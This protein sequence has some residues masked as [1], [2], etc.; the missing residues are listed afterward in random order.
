[1]VRLKFWSNNQRRWRLIPY[2][3]PLFIE[4]MPAS[5]SE[6]FI[7]VYLC[8]RIKVVMMLLIYVLRGAFV[9]LLDVKSGVRE[10]VIVFDIIPSVRGPQRVLAGNRERAGT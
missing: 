5:C 4:I 8:I 6:I 9:D 7:R 10:F 2:N 3:H 1:M